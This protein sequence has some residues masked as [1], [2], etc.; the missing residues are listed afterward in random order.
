MLHKIKPYLLVILFVSS[1]AIINIGV[2][3]ASDQT[4]TCDDTSCSADTTGALFAEENLAP[5]DSV[6]KT[7]EAIN[8]YSEARTFAVEIAN[9]SD[10]TPS[11]AAVLEITISDKNN[12]IVYGPKTISQWQ[13]DGF[14]ELSSAS[15]E[16][17][18]EYSFTV[19]ADSAAGNDYQNQ[20]LTFDLNLGFD[21]LEESE[22]AGTTTPTPTP[23]QADTP[24]SEQISSAAETEDEEETPLA[25]ETASV[26][27]LLTAEEP[28]EEP[29]E[30]ISTPEP[31][32]DDLPVG[33]VRGIICDEQD[34]LW[35]LP[36][37]IQALITAPI[38]W[39]AYQKK[40]KKWWL[41]PA[42]LALLSQL[43]HYILGGCNC[44]TSDWCLNYWL[45]N[46][47]ILILSIIVYYPF[48]KKALQNNDQ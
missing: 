28:F 30:E 3:R 44:A 8:N 40:F 23:I 5:G 42:V 12:D 18:E 24:D 31:E 33:E 26:L 21:S 10:S 14:V 45:F 36:L 17:P 20:T 32:P 41:I 15:P 47:A 43:A 19:A 37:V 25:V 38:L 7:V 35:W 27:G 13:E 22:V 9:F 39:Q 4:I 48:A 16:E 34:Y 46:L 1:F 11:L 6:T 2:S 29:E